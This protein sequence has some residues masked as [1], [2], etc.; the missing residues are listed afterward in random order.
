MQRKFAAWRGCWAQAPAFI[1]L[2][3][4][5]LLHAVQGAE[6]VLS[7]QSRI[8]SST[9]LSMTSSIDGEAARSSVAASLA[10]R[11]ALAAEGATRLPPAAAAGIEPTASDAPSGILTRSRPPPIAA[12]GIEST[13]SDAP[14]GISTRS[15]SICGALTV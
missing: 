3:A 2:G 10:C 11:D 9:P 15:G 4:I 1:A 14:A 12:A 13:V 5:G 7:P 8:T 6:R